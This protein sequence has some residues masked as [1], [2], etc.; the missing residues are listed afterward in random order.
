[1][2]MTTFD[3]QPPLCENYDND[4]VVAIW[5]SGKVQKFPS[6]AKAK[7]L[8]MRQHYQ[9]LCATAKEAWEVAN[10]LLPK[11]GLTEEEVKELDHDKLWQYLLDIAVERNPWAAATDIPE[12]NRMSKRVTAYGYTIHH[13]KCKA[14]ATAKAPKQAKVIAQVFLERFEDSCGIVDDDIEKILR[15]AALKSVLV[16]KQPVMRIFSYYR[17]ILIENEVITLRN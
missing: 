2:S 1:M 4:V 14:F 6:L 9:Y 7:T 5:P 8:L 3:Q 13:D 11:L 17:A 15:N 16:T 10:G 12:S